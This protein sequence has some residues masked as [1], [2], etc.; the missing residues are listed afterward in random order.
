[1]AN[2]EPLILRPSELPK[3]ERPGGQ[4]VVPLLG[5]WNVP[6]ANLFLA[7][8][9]QPP[10]SGEPAA[11]S[12]SHTHP[13]QELLLVLQGEAVVEVNGVVHVLHAGDVAWVPADVP[14]SLAPGKLGLLSYS[15][16]TSGTPSRTM[17]QAGARF[18]QMSDADLRQLGLL[19]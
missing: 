9:R 12:A 19:P 4:S 17:V 2:D 14:H 10:G 3:L 13:E 6:S 11:P 1:V 5:R 16:Y 15:L 8:V 18:E 7:V